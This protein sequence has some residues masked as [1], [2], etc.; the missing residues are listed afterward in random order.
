[1]VTMLVEII[2]TEKIAIASMCTANVKITPIYRSNNMFEMPSDSI[3]E[4]AILKIFLG[5]IS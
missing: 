2:T 1:M 3:S 4:H 5:G